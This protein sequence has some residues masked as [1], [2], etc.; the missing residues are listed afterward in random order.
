MF[1]TNSEMRP[2]TSYDPRELSKDEPNFYDTAGL[3]WVKHVES[4]W[5]IIREELDDV[6]LKQQTFLESYKDLEKVNKAGAWKTAGLMYWTFVSDRYTE[7][8]PKTWAILQHVPNLSSA[9]I[10]LLE[11]ESMIRPHKGDTNAMMRCHM[12][13]K[14]P[15]QAPKCG[16]KVNDKTVSWEEGKIFS[17]NDAQLHTAWN[18]TEQERYILS[19]DVLRPEYVSWR[20]WVSATVL[21]NIYVDVAYQHRQWLKKYCDNHILKSAFRSVSKL[22]FRSLIKFKLPLYNFF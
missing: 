1:S 11:P 2:W 14:V 5:H 16:F 10:L 15:A 7:L 17:F 9:S 22:F 12:G 19:F 4:H 13:L 18:N 6:L 21:G 20:K 8:F 3:D